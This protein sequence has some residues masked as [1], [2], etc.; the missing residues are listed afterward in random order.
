MYAFRIIKWYAGPIDNPCLLNL[1]MR[2]AVREIIFCLSLFTFRNSSQI[3][4]VHGH[5]R[6]TVDRTRCKFAELNHLSPEGQQGRL[7]WAMQSTYVNHQ[8][9]AQ[10]PLQKLDAETELRTWRQIAHC[11]VK[12][13]TMTIK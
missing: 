7:W 8:G 5:R 1:V 12:K 4:R 10:H 11:H 9:F 3:E 6:F 13:I 2:Q